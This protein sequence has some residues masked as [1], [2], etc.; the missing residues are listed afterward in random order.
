MQTFS[1]RWMLLRNYRWAL[2]FLHRHR[3]SDCHFSA[4]R[5]PK[6]LQSIVQPKLRSNCVQYFDCESTHIDSSLGE[7]AHHK[8]DTWKV[9]NFTINQINNFNYV[10]KWHGLSTSTYLLCS[11]DDTNSKPKLSRLTDNTFHS[12]SSPFWASFCERFNKKQYESSIHLG[13]TNFEMYIVHAWT[14]AE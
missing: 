14:M 5:S 9:I 4:P 1:I 3:Q 2:D 7:I 8:T 6:M 10:K 13:A 12:R 11:I